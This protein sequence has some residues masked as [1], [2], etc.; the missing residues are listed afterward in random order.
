M[1][2]YNGVGSAWVLEFHL[3]LC[4][5]TWS[6]VL[7]EI[8]IIIKI[9]IFGHLFERVTSQGLRVLRSSS[10]LTST[11]DANN[12][13]RMSRS[14]RL[15]LDLLRIAVL[16]S[17][18]CCLSGNIFFFTFGA[19]VRLYLHIHNI[20]TCTAVENIEIESTELGNNSSGSRRLKTGFLIKVAFL[21]SRFRLTAIAAKAAKSFMFLCFF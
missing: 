15:I 6:L 12:L 18:L 3:V 8:R 1:I 11:L 10:S 17:F 16:P 4:W 2:Y 13:A 7:P 9:V 20:Y 14:A 19:C 21:F 5:Y